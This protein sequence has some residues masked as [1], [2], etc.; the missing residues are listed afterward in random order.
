MLLDTPI[1]RSS[2]EARGRFDKGG[3]GRAADDDHQGL[4]SIGQGASGVFVKQVLGL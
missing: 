2:A 3:L 4:R 1:S